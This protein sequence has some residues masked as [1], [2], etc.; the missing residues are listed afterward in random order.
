[1]IN[2]QISQKMHHGE[3]LLTYS[4]DMAPDTFIYFKK[5]NNNMVKARPHKCSYK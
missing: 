2:V 3:F 4:F 5:K 1:M